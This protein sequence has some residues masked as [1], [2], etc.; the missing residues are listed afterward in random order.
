M[1]ISN[2]TLNILKNYASINSNIVVLPGNTIKT[3]SPSKSIFSE[4]T[5]SENFP[6]DFGIWD[7]NR[8]LSTIS[9]FNDPDLDFTQNYVRISSGNSKIDYYY[10]E[11][12]LLTTI[13]K[14]ITMP[15][16]TVSFKLSE[17]DFKEMSKVSAV[18]QAPDFAVVGEGNRMYVK[19]F[20]VK[21]DTA[22]KYEF[23]LG[24]NDLGK[25][26]FALFKFE[27]I[28]IISGNYTVSISNKNLAEF[29]NDNCSIKYWIPLEMNS[30]WK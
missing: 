13:N 26:F 25:D 5:I 3:I 7:L 18:L 9:L 10:S 2:E 16:P 1:K 22:N 19:I 4:A 27:N 23:D 30:Y 21:D 6:I 28:K 15:T 17:K 20:N 12:S 14:K 11:K 29:S 24:A 8:F